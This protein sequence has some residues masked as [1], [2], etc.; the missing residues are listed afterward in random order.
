MLNTNR[1][2]SDLKIPQQLLDQDF[3]LSILQRIW[4]NE[5]QIKRKLND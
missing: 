2:R 4:I 5:L 3:S 1:T